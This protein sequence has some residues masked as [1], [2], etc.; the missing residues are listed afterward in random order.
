MQAIEA[1]TAEALNAI[2]ATVAEIGGTVAGEATGSEITQILSSRP[3]TG[4]PD[5]RPA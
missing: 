3:D 4:H 2:D 1:M 5:D